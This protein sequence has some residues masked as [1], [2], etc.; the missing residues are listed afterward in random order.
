M[1]NFARPFPEGVKME[2]SQ[3]LLAIYQSMADEHEAAMRYRLIAN[4][5]DNEDVKKAMHS[6]ADEEIVHYGEFKELIKRLFPEELEKVEQ[7]MEEATGYLDKTEE[8]ES[9][10]KEG[11]KDEE[12]EEHEIEEE[13][14]TSKG[15]AKP[16]KTVKVLKVITK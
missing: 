10:I 16:K 4:N 7:G 12:A 11:D 1:P 3:L 14:K 13:A 2:G 9:E 5:T 15:D 8:L 6:I